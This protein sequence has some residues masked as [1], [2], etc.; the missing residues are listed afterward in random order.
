[1]TEQ[2]RARPLSP[3]LQVYDLPLAARISI[4]HR[5]TGTALSGGI[6]L[7]VYWLW[8]LASG[9]ESY[10]QAQAILGSWLGLLILLGFSFALF[11]HLCHGIRHLIWDMSAGLDKSSAASSN[12]WIIILTL[13]LTALSWGLGFGL[14]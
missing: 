7:L 9:P 6:I 11:L 14:A 4:L 2:R 13:G 10:Q 12:I 1:M 3:H 8:A 5:I